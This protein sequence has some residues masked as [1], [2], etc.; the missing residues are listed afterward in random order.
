M[1]HYQPQ[2]LLYTSVNKLAFHLKDYSLS[3]LDTLPSELKH[4]IIE[5][6]SR[7]TNI[8]LHPGHL[9]ALLHHR[10]RSLNVNFLTKV[11][12]QHIQALSRLPELTQFTA[13]KLDI[14]SCSCTDPNRIPS[15]GGCENISRHLR[16]ALESFTLLV[17]LD[18]SHNKTVVNDEIVLTVTKNSPH[19]QRLELKNCAKITDFCFAHG[20]NS[21]CIDRSRQ[22]EQPKFVA[23]LVLLSCLK[24]LGF[25]GTSISDYGLIEFSQHSKSCHV[26]EE[27]LL[28]GC[29]NITDD[30]IEKILDNCNSLNI[31]SFSKCENVSM[32]SVTKLSDYFHKRMDSSH[33]N[34]SK[35]V[36]QISYTIW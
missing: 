31:F 18:L 30:G 21:Y 36:K 5:K 27:L 6:L 33:R 32:T 25:S 12:V 35:H 15:C 34:Q 11:N 9:T 7:R 19:L 28:N 3:N 20:A 24:S 16:T 14:E 1:G 8:I 29:K 17:T 22:C 23:G 13:S 2:S 26:I 4:L 10:V